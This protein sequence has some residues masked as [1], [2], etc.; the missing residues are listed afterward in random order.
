MKKL[1]AIA[2]LLAAPFAS[3]AS[4]TF[5]ADGNSTTVRFDYGLGYI[6]LDGT[7]GSGTATV[8]V[9]REDG[10]TWQDVKSYT[11]EPDPNAEVYD[12]GAEAQIRINMSGSTSP[13]L[14]WEIRPANKGR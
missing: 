7:F 4:G 9:L 12:F 11:A 5:G 13:S 10:T 6:I 14:Y 1:L 2:L 8:Q 3:A